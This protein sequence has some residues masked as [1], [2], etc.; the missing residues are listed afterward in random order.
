MSVIV[1]ELLW[2]K[3]RIKHVLVLE[4][5]LCSPIVTYFLV[6]PC[7]GVF[8]VLNLDTGTVE[9]PRRRDSDIRLGVRSRHDATLSK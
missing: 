5:Y 9:Q 7:D 1:E 6:S 3:K 4:K 2:C 8:L